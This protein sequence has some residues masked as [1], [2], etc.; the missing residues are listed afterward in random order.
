MAM[1]QSLGDPTVLARVQFTVTKKGP[2]EPP[3]LP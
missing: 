3:A 1:L 2:D